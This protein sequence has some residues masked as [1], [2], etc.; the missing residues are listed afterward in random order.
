MDKKRTL[1]EGF[2]ERVRSAIDSE[3]YFEAS[4]YIYALIEDRLSSLLRNSG[5]VGR[6]GSSTP[7]KML[8]PK[9][10]VLSERAEIDALLRSCLPCAELDQ[11]RDDRNELMHAMADGLLTQS[12]IDKKA[13][14]LATN[15]VDIMKELS[16]GAMRLKKH[17]SKVLT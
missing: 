5:G 17:R 4:W 7:I 8:G 6:N 3:K 15:G 14:L 13:Y 12:E 10:G 2:H 11:W 16:A 9:L 1:F